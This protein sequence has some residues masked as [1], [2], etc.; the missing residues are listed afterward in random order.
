MSSRGRQPTGSSPNETPPA[1]TVRSTEWRRSPFAHSARPNAGPAGESATMR[2]TALVG[3]STLTGMSSCIAAGSPPLASSP[4]P[5][6]SGWHGLERPSSIRAA[7]RSARGVRARAAVRAA[8]PELKYSSSAGRSAQ[9][10]DRAAEAEEVQRVDGHPAAGSVD[11]RHGFGEAAHLAVDHRLDHR[12]QAVRPG[13]RGDRGDRVAGPPEVGVVRDHVDEPRPERGAGL[14]ERPMVGGLR[15][16]PRR[17]IST[18]DLDAG[19]V[20]PAAGPR[21]PERG[22]RPRL[23]RSGRP[24]TQVRRRRPTSAASAQVGGTCR[25]A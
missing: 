24:P 12:P 14:V 19:V 20:E 2:S 17:M 9:L 6:G 11:H 16:G 10:V 15:P 1:R 23:P 4:S 3:A 21:H 18:P 25:A 5:G 22:A 8:R 7:A 13:L